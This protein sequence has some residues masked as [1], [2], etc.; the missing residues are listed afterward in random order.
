MTRAETMRKLAL[1]LTLLLASALGISASTMALPIDTAD[2]DA[3]APRRTGGIAASSLWDSPAAAETVVVQPPRPP[4][5]PSTAPERTPSANPLWPIPLATLSNTRER[6]IFSSSRRPPPAAVASAPVA[7]APPPPPKPRAERPQLSLVGTI[8]GGDE[9]FGIFIDQTTKAALRLKIGDDY[10]GWRLR[11]VQGREVTLER[12]QQTA[13]LSLPQ[14]GTGAAG[15]VRGQAEGVVT[16]GQGLVDS[17]SQ[18]GR[19]A[20]VDPAVLLKHKRDQ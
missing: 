13:I 5:P 18:L 3:D 19:P 9:S 11:S 1:R 8:A 10:Q 2:I 16:P 14:P 6:P 20:L 4:E 15:L 7:K 12:D 17:L